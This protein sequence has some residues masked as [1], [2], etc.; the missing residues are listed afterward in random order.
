M[1]GLLD[2]R[3]LQQVEIFLNLRP[4]GHKL[5]QIVE[6]HRRQFRSI[7]RSRFDNGFSLRLGWRTGRQIAEARAVSCG[8]LQIINLD[9]VAD[10]QGDGAFQDVFQ[11]AEVARIAVRQQG[12]LCLGAEFVAARHAV[13]VFVQQ[14]QNQAAQIFAHLAQRGHMQGN[15]VEAV[16]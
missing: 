3:T 14:A 8:Q 16:V 9:D 2:N 4:A 13:A 12:F 1:Q 15:D 11:F 6:I 10:R 5:R 7:V